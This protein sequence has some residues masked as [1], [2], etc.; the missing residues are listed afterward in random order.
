MQK[1]QNCCKRKNVMEEIK[2]QKIPKILHYVGFGRGKKSEF[3]E[4]NI[5]SW[6]KYCPDWQI[7]EWNEDNFD[8]NCNPYVRE[9][10]KNKKW[11]FVF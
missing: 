8:V 2:Q 1:W 10:F 9:A 11:A 7:K 3:I 6:K 4:R 5:A